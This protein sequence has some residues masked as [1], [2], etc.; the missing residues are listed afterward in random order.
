M[1]I[2]LNALVCSGDQRRVKVLQIL[3]GEMSIGMELRAR[4]TRPHAISSPGTSTA[5]S[6]DAA[7]QHSA[8][9]LR[10]IKEAPGGQ[11]AAGVAFAPAAEAIATPVAY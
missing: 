9:L 6:F 5:S 3:L 8:E 11:R 7:I 10:D 4:A 2:Q 1:E